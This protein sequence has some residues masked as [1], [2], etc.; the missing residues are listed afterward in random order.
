MPEVL[1]DALLQRAKANPAGLAYTYEGSHLTFG[2]LAERAAGRAAALQRAG[3]RPGD[4]VAIVMS[5]GLPFL[6]MFWGLQLI[7]A[8]PSTFNPDVPER[9]SA[10]RVAVAGQHWLSRMTPLGNSMAPASPRSCP[11]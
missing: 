6:E 2:Q 1:R 5:S 10:R 11:T 7:A 9:R 4:R 8:M 3:V